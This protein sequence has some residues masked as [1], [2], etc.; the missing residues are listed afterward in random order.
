MSIKPIDCKKHRIFSENLR[1]LYEDNHVI[2]VYKPGGVLVQGDITGD[3]SLMDIVK[4]YIKDRYKKPGNVFLGLV[5]RLDRPVSGVVVLAKTSKGASRLSEQFRFRHI[6]KIYL[7]QVYG[8]MT[9]KEGTLSSYL[10]RET[11]GARLAGESEPGAQSAVLSYKVL[12]SMAGKSLLEITLHTGR[13]HQIRAQLASQGHPIVGDVKY[14]APSALSDNTIR[15]LAKS[16]SFKHP[17]KDE[18]I[19]VES[20]DPDWDCGIS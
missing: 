4:Q 20:P 6:T 12:K 3:I 1:I 10:R 8:H 16:L 11:K 17:T 7:A 9:P 5:H 19:T 2:A 13:K 14:G 18:I 15:L